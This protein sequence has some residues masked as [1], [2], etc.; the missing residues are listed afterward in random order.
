MND[1]PDT[2]GGPH[3]DPGLIGP[4]GRLSRL[5]KGAPKPKGPSA[6]QIALEKKQAE[7]ADA[8]LAEMERQRLQPTPE[9]PKPLPPLP[10]PSSTGAAD[11]EQAAA[12]ARR[13]AAKRMAPGR[14]TIFAGETSGSSLGGRKTILG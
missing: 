9:A 8:Q 1:L 7:L 13:K 14:S 2:F 10:P 11:E 3:F 5:H 6:S 4:D 12:D